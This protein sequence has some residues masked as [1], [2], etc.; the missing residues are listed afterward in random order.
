M[1]KTFTILL[2]IFLPALSIFIPFKGQ[3]FGGLYAQTLVVHSTGTPGH[4]SA[5]LDVNATNKGVLISR[6][7]LTSN[8]DITTIPSA[9]TSLLVYNTATSGVYPN[10]VLPGYYYWD[11]TRWISMNGLTGGIST[12]SDFYALMPGDNTATVAAGAAVSFPQN[13][14]TNG[15]ITRSSATQF[16]IPI[17]GTYMV[18]W[19]VS[20]Q[21]AGQLVL[22]LDGV[23]KTNTTVGRATGTSQIVGNRLITTTE[24][25][26]T[27]RVINPPGSPLALTIT[28][29]AGGT[30]AVS[31]SLVITRVQ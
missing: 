31:A 23:V 1:V 15:I 4:A 7:S 19:Q 8:S 24:P 6:V 27:L 17:V 20:V 13:G 29:L 30:N 18:S 16:V 22:E 28:P 5:M 9:A 25:N 12:F 14:P 2:F 26:A 10:N 21:E 11:S 3:S